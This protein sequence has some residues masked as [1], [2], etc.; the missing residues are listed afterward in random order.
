MAVKVTTLQ[1]TA[2]TGGGTQNVAHGHGTT[3]E[4]ALFFFSKATTLE[5]AR[6]GA[7]FGVGFS[8]GTTD[9][10][11][12]IRSQDNL[13]ATNPR[14]I[15]AD[16]AVQNIADSASATDGVAAASF[17]ATNLTLTW[18]EAP[19]VA[20]YINVV[21]FSGTAGLKV[22]DTQMT[23]TTPVAVTH[24]LGLTT[25]NEALIFCIG[26]VFT[27]ATWDGTARTETQWS[28]GVSHW[29]GTST[30]TT[31]CYSY[32]EDNAEVDG[33]PGA[34]LDTNNLLV[35]FNSNYTL[36]GSAAISDFQ[37]NDFDMTADNA[38]IN[39]THAF[40]VIGL[41]SGV[42]A[43]AGDISA[44]TTLASQAY[45]P[46]SWEP[47]YVGMVTTQIETKDSRR[48]GTN[49]DEAGA[50]GISALD[51]SQGLSACHA[52]ENDAPTTNTQSTTAAKAVYMPAD[53]GTLAG[54]ASAGNGCHASF[55]SLDSTGW[56]INTTGL[57][58]NSTQTYWIAWAI[59]SDGG[60]PP[61][62]DVPP[63]HY[64]HRHHNLAG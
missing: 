15:T 64:H 12:A 27:G 62:G 57:S 1:F 4:G 17:G 9:K 29:D 46:L 34:I 26:N 47:Q 61:A 39:D 38:G 16:D 55:T 42:S 20:Y 24:N 31:R 2:S 3:P 18:S 48:L 6:A 35:N 60:A 63:L 33:M 50:W 7:N 44:P 53:D 45:T 49:A 22:L 30:F 58:A 41:P 28:F 54:S 37:T 14:Y 59:E 11:L 32:M 25:S 40:M 36:I 51:S 23:G 43:W 52:T 13:A 10:C 19:S 21:F 56:T 8:D 5:S